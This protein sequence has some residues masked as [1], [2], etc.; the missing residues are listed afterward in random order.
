MIVRIL[1]EGQYRLDDSEAKELDARD[2]LLDGDLDRHDPE[3]FQADLAELIAWV[4]SVGDVI[5]DEEAVA[6]DA[7]LPGEDM[8]LDE[9]IALVSDAGPAE[10]VAHA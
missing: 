3:R 4:R 1:G 8:T 9:V 6:S 10:A 2:E 7:I 5:G